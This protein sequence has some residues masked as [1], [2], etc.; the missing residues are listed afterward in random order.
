MEITADTPTIQVL[1]LLNDEYLEELMEKLP[2]R[3]MR[4][5]IFEMTCG[6]FIQTL[7]DDYWRTFF[8]EETIG[9][10]IG[11]LKTWK[12]DMRN[13][14]KYLKMNEITET[15]DEK[16]AKRG[17]VFPTFAEEILLTVAE[18]FHCR[19]LDEAEEVP[20]SNYLIVQKQ[21][22][23]QAKFERNLQKV[24]DAKSKAK[25]GKKGK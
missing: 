8:Q 15:Q 11:H 19:T 17:V 12:E 16:S 4:K 25:R 10:A 23:A 21:K 1:P 24:F 3:A 2:A 9:A 22:S 18:F 20:F 6:E 7:D 13:L 14:D 5:S